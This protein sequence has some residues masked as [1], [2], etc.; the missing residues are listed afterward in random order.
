MVT[1]VF[2]HP[3]LI[4]IAFDGFRHDYVNETLTPNLFRVAHNGVTGN[5]RTSQ[6]S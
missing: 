1:H 6:T 2:G 3:I 5:V 4:V